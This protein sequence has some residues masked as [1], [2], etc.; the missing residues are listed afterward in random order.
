MD[1]M[2]IFRSMEVFHSY[3]RNFGFIGEKENTA[4]RINRPR[5]ESTDYEARVSNCQHKA[6]VNS[7]GVKAWKADGEGH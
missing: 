7:V 5:S 4:V 1:A 2:E 6:L 3:Y